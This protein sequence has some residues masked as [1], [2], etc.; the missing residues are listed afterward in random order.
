MLD[1]QHGAAAGRG[2]AMSAQVTLQRHAIGYTRVSDK[3]QELSPEAQRAAIESYA[4]REG[5]TILAWYHDTL[6]GGTPVQDRPG[7]TAAIIASKGC[8]ALLVA[9]RDR[10]ARDVM[11][12]AQVQRGLSKGCALLSAAGEGNGSTPADALMRTILD[13]M[14]E[15]ER[16]LIRSRTK[17]ALQ[18]KR[19]RGERAGNI[20]FGYVAD[21]QGL[22]HPNPQEQATIQLAHD[23][24]DL[25]HSQ[26]EIVA[27][28]QAQG[29]V[30]RTGKPLGLYQVQ[31]LLKGPPPPT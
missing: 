24:R 28:L 27:Q 15:Y 26:W 3:R 21:P 14:S 18:A 4:Q 11:I 31:R 10:I 20:P 23:L 17:A 29:H 9:K 25:N 13:G 19:R 8:T 1:I 2:A 22:L 6:T 30:G 7:L 12:A 5:F 16:A